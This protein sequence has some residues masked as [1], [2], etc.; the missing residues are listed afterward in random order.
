MIAGFEFR[1]EKN[2]GIEWLHQGEMIVAED[3]ADVATPVGSQ[4]SRR[5]A[6]VIAQLFNG[7]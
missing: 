1:S 2:P 5:S 3:E 7:P 4:H 6:W